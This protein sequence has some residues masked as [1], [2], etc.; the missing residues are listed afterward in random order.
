MQIL[1]FV[2]VFQVQALISFSLLI[3]VR[4]SS[5]H[6]LYLST[7]SKI[8]RPQIILQSSDKNFVSLMNKATNELNDTMQRLQLHIDLSMGGLDDINSIIMQSYVYLDNNPLPFI[9]NNYPTL[10]EL[11]SC[12]Q[13]QMVNERNEY[14]YGFYMTFRSFISEEHHDKVLV[15]IRETVK[16]LGMKIGCKEGRNFIIDLGDISPFDFRILLIQNTRSHLKRQFKSLALSDGDV[17]NGLIPYY[18]S[19][20]E[21]MG[22]LERAVIESMRLLEGEE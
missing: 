21:S 5:F 17:S 1:C 16:S 7:H 22:D 19:C 3:F 13:V 12:N 15:S 20:L 2:M 18:Q 14:A 11:A 4:L 9:S 8:V 6:S 10:E